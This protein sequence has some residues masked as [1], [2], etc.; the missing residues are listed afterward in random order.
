[1]NYTHTHTHTHTHTYT[2]T[3]THTHTHTTHTDYITRVILLP[4]K[5]RPSKKNPVP[6]IRNLCLLA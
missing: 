4:I 3:H 5:V 2:H 6:F 1:M